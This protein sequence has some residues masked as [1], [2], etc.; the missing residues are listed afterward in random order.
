MNRKFLVVTISAVLFGGIGLTGCQRA[1]APATAGA[2]A[3]PATEATAQSAT[4]PPPPVEAAPVETGPRIEYADVVDVKPLNEK[5]KRYGDV[6]SVD[7]IMRTVQEPKQVCQDVEVTERQPERDGNVGGTVAGAVVGGL[8]GNQVGKGSGRKAA[9][10]AGAVAGGFAGREI[11]KR[12]VGGKEIKRIENQCHT[13]T[14]DV[15]KQDGYRVTYRT[16]EGKSVTKTMSE[17]PG[18]RVYLDTQSHVAGYEVSYRYDGELRTA[19]LDQ[20]PGDRLTLVDGKVMA[21]AK[22]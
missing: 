2:V 9:T 19:R 10:V 20:R 4:Q 13:E 17:K 12:H 11:D 3:S 7:P 16:P 14:V 1:E 8:L 15:Q 6:V 21:I 5:Q 22:N 18:S